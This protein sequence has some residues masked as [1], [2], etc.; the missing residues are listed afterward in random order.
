[1]TRAA[2]A[3]LLVLLAAA[4][5]A[6]AQDSCAASFPARLADAKLA[7]VAWADAIEAFDAARP[8]V[9]WFE[10]HCRFLSPLERA[11]RK[12]DDANAFVCD[13]RKPA[14]LTADLVIRYSVAPS[15][16]VYQ[17]E[18]G[19]NHRCQVAD[20]AARIGLVFVE[21][22]LLERLAVLCWDNDTP[23]CVTARAAI[24]AARAKGH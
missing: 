17:A 14:G 21:P 10:A 23:R 16:G 5:T 4:G 22:S 18:H 9:E 12:L 3:A 7:L 13:A 2:L 8:R 6:R 1:M 11:V 15:V 20:R 19:E 24:D